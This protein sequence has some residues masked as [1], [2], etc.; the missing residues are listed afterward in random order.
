MQGAKESRLVKVFQISSSLKLMKGGFSGNLVLDQVLEGDDN[1]S[2][3]IDGERFE[4][5]GGVRVRLI[6]VS[7]WLPQRSSSKKRT[8]FCRFLLFTTH[9]IPFRIQFWQGDPA[10]ALQRTLAI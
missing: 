2:L 10:A 3:F 8:Y 9:S 5:V 6:R 1:W 7:R 4:V